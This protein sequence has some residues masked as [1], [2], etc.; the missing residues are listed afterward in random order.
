MLSATRSL[1][2]LRLQ[3]CCACVQRPKTLPPPRL[4][5]NIFLVSVPHTLTQTGRNVK[6]K[7]GCLGQRERG[8]MTMR[9]KSALGGRDLLPKFAAAT[10]L[11]L[12]IIEFFSQLNKNV[13]R[14][15]EIE[16]IK[17]RLLNCAQMEREKRRNSSGTS[18]VAHWA[19]RFLCFYSI[20]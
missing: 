3:F 4:I 13:I 7:V 5:K 20:V 15:S 19:R 11:L 8:R 9:N 10:A 18:F 6:C 14:S 16:K 12:A 17:S 2:F 1:S